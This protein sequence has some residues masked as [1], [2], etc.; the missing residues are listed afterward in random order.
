MSRMISGLAFF[1]Y[2]KISIARLALTGSGHDH[3]AA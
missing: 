1:R 3:R 2:R